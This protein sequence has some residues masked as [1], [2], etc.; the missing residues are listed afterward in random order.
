MTH[1]SCNVLV[2]AF[3]GQQPQRAF[4]CVL[5]RRTQ[6]KCG[7]IEQRA[8]LQ[9]CRMGIARFQSATCRLCTM[10][11]CL[12]HAVHAA[13]TPYDWIQQRFYVSP[14]CAWGNSYE[15]SNGISPDTSIL[16]WNDA[17][18]H[19][20]TR[21]LDEHENDI[22]TVSVFF[23]RFNA[24]ILEKFLFESYSTLNL[25]LWTCCNTS[26]SIFFHFDVFI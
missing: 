6:P 25:N 26:N 5:L 1:Y 14:S 4:L 16:I 2:C 8:L 15:S 21:D 24:Y 7:F 11:Q 13:R 22:V 23:S 17:V 12:N 20:E 3:H 19:S 9:C 10:C 18:S